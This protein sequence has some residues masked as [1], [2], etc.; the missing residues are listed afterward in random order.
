M[1]VIIRTLLILLAAA[2]WLSFCKAAD[3]PAFRGNNCRTGYAGPTGYPSGTATW[4]L[5]LGCKIVSSP[6]VAGGILYV[7]AYDSCI[8]AVDCS[9]GKVLWKKK[10]GGWIDGSAMVT[11]ERVIIGSRDST[12]YVLDRKTG[13]ILGLLSAGIQ[14]SSPAVTSGGTIL[15]GVG[16]FKGGIAAYDPTLISWARS[17]QQWSLPLAQFTYSSPAVKGQA[18]VIGAT[19]GKLYGIDTWEKDTIWSLQTGGLIYHS[20]PAIDGM[21][22]YFAAGDEDRNVYA[23]D[24]LTGK[25]I[26]Q[27]AISS[28]S[29][30]ALTALTKKKTAR[31]LSSSDLVGLVKLSPAARKKTIQRL[32]QQGVELPRIPLAKSLMKGKTGLGKVTATASGDFIPIGGMKTSSVAVGPRTCM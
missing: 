5:S 27:N 11:G 18:A 15:S 17:P 16:S 30:D 22:V 29:T 26:W 9:T 14:L 19:D 6:V 25:V 32:R 21:N 20:T 4:T 7:G 1:N 8:Y 13:D 23:L 3:W 24:L 28:V 10:T 2:A 12:I 31:P